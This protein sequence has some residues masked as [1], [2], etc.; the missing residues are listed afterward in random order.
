MGGAI[1]GNTTWRWCFFIN[2]PVSVVAFV[3]LFMHLK[4]NPTK[5]RTVR[6]VVDEFDK[7][8][9]AIFLAGI[10]L[11]LLGFVY[12]EIEGFSST[13]AIVFLAVGGLFLVAF[14]PWEFY[15]E[16]KWPQVKPIIPPR[17]FRTRTT[18]LILVA[19]CCHG[20]AL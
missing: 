3:V 10:V 18:I 19:V 11:F 8:G 14:V 1:A 16:K 7:I 5:K 4:L 12:A 6:D 2:I 13:R 15:A 20:L 9:Y 17:L